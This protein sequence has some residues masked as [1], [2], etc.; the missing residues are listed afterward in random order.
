[1]RA[2]L[3]APVP[4][5]LAAALA[6]VALVT[7]IGLVLLWPRGEEPASA[8]GVGVPLET[9]TAEVASVLP[10]PCRVPGAGGCR[11]VEAEI[12]DGPREGETAELTIGDQGDDIELEVGDR[13]RIAE[14][15]LPEGANIGGVE[16]DR[17]LFAD[18]E[19]RMPLLWLALLFAV[20]VVVAA[21]MR[22]LRALVG[23]AATLGVL[24][25]FVV[26]AILDGTS[27]VAVALVGAL[28]AML[29]TI[30]L[31]HGLGPKAVAACLGTTI[32]LG[33]TLVLATVFTELT[34]LTGLASEEASYLRVTGQD[35][36]LQGLVLAGMVIGALGVLDDLTVS[37]AST[38]M[39]LRRANPEQPFRTL[40]SRGVSVGH[41][42]VAALVNTLVLAYAGASLPLLLLFSVGDTPFGD[43]VN[44]EAVASE[45]VATL[46]GSIGLVAAVPVTTALAALLAPYSRERDTHVH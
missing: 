39:A 37:Q 33:L 19:R 41:D 20:F 14:N 29:L 26:P 46:V 30:P 2:M 31:T 27:P 10:T 4:R 16:V 15:E 42:H 13:I 45:I 40:F 11:R 21:G 44:N 6:A 1:M 3:S 23:L 18:F 9:V 24:V 17:W 34:H 35:L 36:S 12:V 43:A 28:A 32:A 5:A 8:E 25:L 38:V 7:A 22:G